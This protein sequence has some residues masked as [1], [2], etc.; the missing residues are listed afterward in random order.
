M[1]IAYVLINCENRSEQKTIS[2]LNNFFSIV[3][4]SEVNGIYYM[5]VKVNSDTPYKLKETITLRVRIIKSI[6]HEVTQNTKV[7]YQLHDMQ[8]LNK[9]SVPLVKTK[10]T[11]YME[12][13]PMQRT[14][15][16]LGKETRILEMVK[17]YKKAQIE[18]INDEL[19]RLTIDYERKC[20]SLINLI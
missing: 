16:Q 3:E 9:D 19:K 6:E 18:F 5:V 4:V 2:K 15:E 10:N 1:L 8:Y 11:I 12:V 13:K 20:M 7:N 17:K 14:K